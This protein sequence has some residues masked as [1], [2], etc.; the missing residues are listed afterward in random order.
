[1]DS[2]TQEAPLPLNSKSAIV[3]TISL[4]LTKQSSLVFHWATRLE[5]GLVYVHRSARAKEDG[6]RDQASMLPSYTIKSSS[7]IRHGYN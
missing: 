3:C 7:G 2:C 5:T 4:A 1:M 6:E